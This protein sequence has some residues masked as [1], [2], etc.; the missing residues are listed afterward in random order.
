[1]ARFDLTDFEW[2]N[3]PPAGS[4]PK[5]KNTSASRGA[6]AGIGDGEVWPTSRRAM[7][8]PPGGLEQQLLAR[9]RVEEATN[10]GQKM[11]KQ[12]FIPKTS[13]RREVYTKERESARLV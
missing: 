8:G 5:E 10:G 13:R 11:R 1:M 6:P 9:E 3:F 12:D 7:F 4:F 2:S